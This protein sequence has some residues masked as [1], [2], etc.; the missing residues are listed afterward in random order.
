MDRKLKSKL[1]AW[2][3]EYEVSSF[4]DN[5]PVQF[6]RYYVPDKPMTEWSFE[7]FANIEIMAVIAS[8][9][10]YGNR[11]SIISACENVKEMFGNS[12][13]HNLKHVYDRYVGSRDSFYRFYTYSDLAILCGRLYHLYEDGLLVHQ[14]SSKLNS[15]QSIVSILIDMF[16]GVTGFPI[17]EKSACKRLCLLLRWMVRNESCVDI[18]IWHNLR[19]EN[20]LI[21]LDTHVHKMA[22]ELG[23][24]K[25]KQADMKTAVEITNAM[26]E[27]FPNDPARGDFALFGYGISKASD[28]P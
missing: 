5:D 9:L 23:L 1:I 3:D 18:G 28:K 19:R 21:P 14:I 15:N 26:R 24:T 13:Y 10:A 17:S 27:V 11:K 16:Y 7:E 22:L 2:A 6:P 12:P 8:W 4:C 25:R 20:I